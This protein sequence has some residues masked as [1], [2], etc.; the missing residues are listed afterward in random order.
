VLI[1]ARQIEDGAQLTSDLV[2]VGAGPA[3]ISIV[4]RLRSSGLSICLLDGGGF[5]PEV[6]TQRLYRGECIGDRYFRLDGCR[7]RQF[8][9]SSNRWGGWCRPLDPI[10]FERRDWLPWSGWPINQ[11]ELEPFY[12]DAAELLQL[13]TSRF[14]VASWPDGMPPPMDMS[15]SNFEN[16]IVQYSPETNFGIR[17]RER[18]ANA[19]RVTIVLH[20]NVTEL[21][22]DPDGDR[23]EAVHVRTLSGRSFRVQGRAV[24]LATGGIENARLLLVSRRA[25]GAGVGNEHDLVG[26]FFMEHLHAPAGHLIVTDTPID[27]EF[28]RKASYDGRLVRGL[29][30]PT[31]DAQARH[32]LLACSISVERDHYP[33]GTPFVGWHPAIR[34]APDRAY[35]QLQRRGHAD[36]AAK[37]KGGVD[38]IWNATRIVETWRS[39]REARGRYAAVS[40]TKR[41]QLLSLY[42]RSEQAPNPLSRVSLSERRDAL[43]IPESRLDWQRHGS[44]TGSIL[45]WLARLDAD[46]QR[47][48]L[49]HV[50]LAPEDWEDKIVGGPHHMGTTRMSADPRTGVVD[51]RCRVHSVK[52]LYIAGSSVFTTGGHANPTFTLVALALRL[53]DELHRSL[54]GNHRQ[55]RTVA[56]EADLGV[57]THKTTSMD[58]L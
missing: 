11:T 16:A 44:D 52:N 10:D 6:A 17:Y 55:D 58:K 34:T 29:L 51:P 21:V 25:R 22:L 9:G 37:L 35:L 4:D 3:G 54:T 56:G 2:V 38:R 46:V 49:G 26:R 40:G 13:P 41:G 5:L 15:D 12:A 7:N 20:A 27:R 32:R 43:G 18:I 8:G 50:V 1:D 36:V 31:A 33:Y 57:E 24:V 14:D 28:Y 42:F 23:I 53:A 45:S 19:N 48:S 30:T 39:A 47:K